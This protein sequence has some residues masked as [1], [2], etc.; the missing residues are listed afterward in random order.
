MPDHS[1]TVIAGNKREAFVPGSEATKQSSL[2]CGEMD[3]FAS[4]AMTVARA[5]AMHGLTPR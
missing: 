1:P 2:V 5:S 3:C 4:L